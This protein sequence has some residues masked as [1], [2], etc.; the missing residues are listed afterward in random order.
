LLTRGPGRA[1]DQA[2]EPEEPT[3]AA[4]AEEAPVEQ[5]DIA[6]EP[7]DD[8]AEQ[9]LAELAAAEDDSVIEREKPGV[10]TRFWNR[11]TNVWPLQE[12]FKYDGCEVRVRDRS[13]GVWLDPSALANAAVA[14]VNK[15]RAPWQQRLD[16][17]RAPVRHGRHD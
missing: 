2:W 7:A 13:V 12:W 3:A 15:K 14:A 17:A 16:L 4:P 10:G 11:V 6:A 1:N 5:V 9:R 8:D